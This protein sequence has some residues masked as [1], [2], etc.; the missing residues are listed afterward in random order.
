MSP[1]YAAKSF[2]Y[3]RDHGAFE[4]DFYNGFFVPPSAMFTDLMH[5][6]LKASGLF[7]Y[8]V[9]SSSYMEATHVLESKVTALYG[10]YSIRQSPLAVVQM[11]FLLLQCG[12]KIPRAILEKSYRFQIPIP[13]TSARELVSGWSV[14]TWRILDGFARDVSKVLTKAY[15]QK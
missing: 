3:A 4:S 5:R 11:E 9:D 2:V 12:S 15:L 14:A 7:G 10:D 1:Q 8:V 6:W 13:G